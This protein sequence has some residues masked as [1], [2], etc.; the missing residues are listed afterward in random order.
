MLLTFPLIAY[1]LFFMILRRAGVDRRW[2]VIAAAV[3]WGTSIALITEGLSL[4]RL[5]TRTSIASFWFAVCAAAFLYYSRWQHG[6]KL[7]SSVSAD[8]NDYHFIEALDSW[9]WRMLVGV[10]IILVDCRSEFVTT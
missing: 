6:A 8:S 7:D 4:T 2:A 3:F 10:G 1:L 5:L 9:S